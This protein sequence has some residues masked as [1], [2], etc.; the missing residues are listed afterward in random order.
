M[1][2]ELTLARRKSGSASQTEQR[3]L[4]RTATIGAPLIVAGLALIVIGTHLLTH[5][6]ALPRWVLT[7]MGIG[8]L[9]KGIDG[10]LKAIFGSSFSTGLWAA[11]A[12]LWTLIVLAIIA[13]WL[14]LQH[15]TALP[16]HAPAFV[17]PSLF[18]NHPLGTDGFGRDYLARVIYGS[19]VSLVLGLGSVAA[20]G[21]IGTTIG[22]LAGYVGGLVERLLDILVDVVLAFPPLVL[23]LAIVAV[24]RPSLLTEFIALGILTLPSFARLAKASTL[25]TVSRDFV[26]ASRSIGTR[27]RRILWHDIVPN[28]VPPL[29]S[30]AM[31][32]VAAL[33]IAEA[34]LSFL[35]LG[36]Q[37][38]NPSWGNMIAQAQ[39]VLQHNPHALLVPA[40]VL[41]ATVLAFNRLA[42]A[43][44]SR[45]EVQVSQL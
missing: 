20:G 38:P 43:G 41:F 35:G 6:S 24:M 25:S 8:I 2:R 31:A 19:R 17:R 29:A 9:F 40:S 44:R 27:Q 39:P 34:S 13:S 1:E 32:I 10:I 15:P 14:P 11:I 5:T 30:Y 21:T 42:E 37:P 33:M 7:V 3:A 4:Y 26:V 22:I 12:W 36:V 18:S 45:H 28:V 16:L 23:L